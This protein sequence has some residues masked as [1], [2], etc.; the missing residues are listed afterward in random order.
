MPSSKTESL[1]SSANPSTPAIST[2]PKA[3]AEI[4]S[5]RQEIDLLDNSLAQ[6][7]LKRL[8][9]S[10]KVQ[11]LKNSQGQGRYSPGREQ[12]IVARLKLLFPQIPAPT[13]EGIFG[14]IL[15]WMRPR[16]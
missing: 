10:Q 11:E 6:L 15:D 5:L 2:D 7:L 9:L 13:L 3:D 14:I 4:E 16:N 1:I 12:Q 8:S